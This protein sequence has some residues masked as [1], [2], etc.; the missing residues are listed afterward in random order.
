MSETPQE[1]KPRV[2]TEEQAVQ[3]IE[4]AFWRRYNASPDMQKKLQGKD[5][6]IL[7]EIP[8]GKSYSFHVLDGRMSAVKEGRADKPDV[9]I[10]VSRA[11]LFA[12]FNGELK[13]LQA[14]MT[15]RV[16][17][18]ASFSDLLFAKSLLGW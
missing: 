6:L 7:L 10:T 11:D 18:K 9:V 12:M 4:A 1:P 3:R 5:R 16:K 8:D 14:Y 15:K 13:P 2:E 17:V